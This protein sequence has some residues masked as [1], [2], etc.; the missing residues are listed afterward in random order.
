[1]DEK[2]LNKIKA[3]AM[4]WRRDLKFKET[5]RQM[6]DPAFFK[7]CEDTIAELEKVDKIDNLHSNRH[8]YKYLD[9]SEIVVEGW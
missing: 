7:W 8:G 6:W 3:L 9:I 4:E 2:K 1:M 5:C